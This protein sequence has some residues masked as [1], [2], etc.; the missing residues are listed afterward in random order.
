MDCYNRE[1]E[2][3]YA[4]FKKIRLCFSCSQ[5][6][7]KDVKIIFKDS[8]GGKKGGKG[9]SSDEDEIEKLLARDSPKV[10]LLILILCV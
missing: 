10:I 8:V 9:D 2:W 5:K 1:I 4:Y 7:L 6:K 3:N